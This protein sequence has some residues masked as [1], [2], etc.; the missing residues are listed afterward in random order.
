MER[1]RDQRGA[2]HGRTI[3]AGRRG[4]NECLAG[5]EASQ[6]S[7]SSRWGNFITVTDANG[8]TA[9]QPYQSVIS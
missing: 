9:S 5:K 8:L 7:M 1:G 3:N 4:V 2:G 6:V